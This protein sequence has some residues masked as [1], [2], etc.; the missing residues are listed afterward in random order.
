MT[1]ENKMKK[2]IILDLDNTIYPVSSIGERLFK[3]LFAYIEKS[4][5]FEGSFN[6]IIL[7]IQRTPFQKVA[8]NFSFSK[9]LLD[10][11]LNIHE[12]LTF[13]EPMK[14]FEDYTEIRKL[15]QTKY[16]VTSG[17]T[18]LQNSKVEQLGIKNDFEGI[19][20]IDLQH[21]IRTKKAIFLQILNEQNY[22]TDEVLVIGDDLDSEI[23][24]GKEL[25]IDTVL[26]NKLGKYFN[27][28]SENIITD[29]K[30]LKSFL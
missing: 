3:E 5:E 27:L 26:Y 20:I 18:K 25:G 28:N 4:G 29:F 7:E 9:Q 16:L 11:C 14:T 22:S 23:K 2:A 24:A 6:E 21:S 19:Y 1:Q 12:N 15:P 13:D 17:F 30:E 10:E 8:A